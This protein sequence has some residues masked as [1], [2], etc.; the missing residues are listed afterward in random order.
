MECEPFRSLLLRHR[1]RTG[2]TQRDL[3]ARAGVHMR[4]V[5]FW[6]AG[7]SY[8]TAERLQALIRAFLEMRGLTPGH[9]LPEAR[10]LWSAVEREASRMRTPFDEEWFAVALATH[11]PPGPAAPRLPNPGAEASAD[12]ERLRLR[13]VASA[14]TDEG[15]TAERAQ[16]WGEAPD[17]LA[18]VGR[19][20][21]RA[22]LQRWVLEERCRLV[23]VLGMGGI[24]KTSLA[25]WVAES[26]ADKFERVYW[27]SLRNAPP[28][29]EWLAGAI[30]FLSDQQWVPPV[31]EFEQM[32][33]LQ[34]LLKTRRCLLV[35]DNS[36]T[37]FEPGQREV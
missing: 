3:A 4:S 21:E 31:S 10:E 18:F 26:V 8:P 33:T 14:D 24:G 20:E 13:E 22:L 7:V 2:L 25:A 15:E 6:E 23:A 36:E 35:L 5:Q 16:D 9:E 32:S 34:Q 29:T 11:A 27:R 30:G 17:T 28:V 37:L 19:V 12:V 1:G